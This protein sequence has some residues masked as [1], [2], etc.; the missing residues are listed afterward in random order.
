MNYPVFYK[1]IAKADL[2]ARNEVYSTVCDVLK[3][4]LLKI[5]VFWDVTLYH[6]VKIFPDCEGP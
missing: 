6:W 3:L 2:I 1:I 4:V 5:Q